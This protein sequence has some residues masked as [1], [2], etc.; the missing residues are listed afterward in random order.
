MASIKPNT[1][2]R[3]YQDFVKE[4]YGVPNDQYWDSQEML[5]NIQRFTLRGIK[6]IRKGDTSK[7]ILNLLITQT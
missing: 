5:T 7:I 6:G 3:E 1:T 2:I 4:V